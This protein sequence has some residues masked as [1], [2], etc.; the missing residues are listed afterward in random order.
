MIKRTGM[1]LQ[2]VPTNPP[3]ADLDA[4]RAPAGGAPGRALIKGVCQTC[5]YEPTR[6][7]RS[8]NA[9]RLTIRWSRRQP[10]LGCGAPL[11]RKRSISATPA[12]FN[13]ALAAVTPLQPWAMLAN[14]QRGAPGPGRLLRLRRG[15]YQ[16]ARALTSTP[17]SADAS[18]ASRR[19]ARRPKERSGAYFASAA[20]SRRQPRL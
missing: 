6:K 12:R 17:W 8:Y 20:G 10:F 19:I 3:G 13:A 4:R 1:Y 18:T 11:S 16:R 15:A 5:R 2:P 7:R 14:G 9:L